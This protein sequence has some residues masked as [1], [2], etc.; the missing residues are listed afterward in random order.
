MAFSIL[1]FNSSCSKDEETSSTTTTVCDNDNS[2][3]TEDNSCSITSNIAN[4]YSESI[5]NDIRSITTNGIP[6]HTITVSGGANSLNSNTKIYEVDA[7]PTLASTSTSVTNNGRPRYRFGLGVNGVP[8]DPA[9]AE[10]FI[11]TNSSTGEYNWDWVFEVTNNKHVTGVDCNNA[12][13]QPDGTYHYHG[14]QVGL[15]DE[16][17]SGL[18]QGTSVPT[19]PM[20]IAWA[21]DG[22][23]VFYK[24][25]PDGTGG[26][27][28]LQSSYALKS[29]D[30][31]GDGI[32]EP[33]GSYNG[34][35]TNDYE[36]VPGGGD[37]DE[38]NGIS[39]SV[40]INGETFS[41][42]YVITDAFPVIPRC[43]S[44]TPSDDFRLGPP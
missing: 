15:A 27:A 29:G 26:I 34:K 14:D 36:Y 32:E 10:P 18:G 2:I 5:A 22:F 19:E 1:A 17:L 33:C 24:Y 42:F 3:S 7:T 44:G 41:Y 23:P 11:F 43:I 40:T 13:V 4:Q 37:L 6:S 39:R 20:Q 9:P 25:A 28:E 38:C 8:F 12:H 21:A 35:Y 16:L 31:P 30:R